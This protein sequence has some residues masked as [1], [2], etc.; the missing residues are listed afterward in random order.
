MKTF[1]SKIVFSFIFCVS[2]IA[3]ELDYVEL[4]EFTLYKDTFLNKKISV[5]A[6]IVHSAHCTLP[7]NKDYYCLRMT[8]NKS[9]DYFLI[10]SDS[11][12]IRKIIDW[13]KNKTPVKVLGRV[14]MMDEI[15]VS[16]QISKS[17]TLVVTSIVPFEFEEKISA[18]FK[19]DW[20]SILDKVV[21][22]P[23][24]DNDVIKTPMESLVFYNAE[25]IF[26]KNNTVS[27]WVRYE[28]KNPTF[29]KEGPIKNIFLRYKF[30]CEVDINGDNKQR[31]IVTASFLKPNEDEILF[32]EFNEKDII[33]PAFPTALYRNLRQVTEGYCEK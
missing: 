29:I 4:R 31:K 1:L 13:R 28:L 7:S 33:S 20:R 24:L 25:D 9:E 17:P 14:E 16:G 6:V 27:I 23:Y 22:I 21:Y 26:V 32:S 11:A 2:C 18:P 19:L 10:K 15:A 5:A 12:N 30:S 3:Q 8:G